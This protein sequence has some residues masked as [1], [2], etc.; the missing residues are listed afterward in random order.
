MNLHAFKEEC[1][2]R[3]RRKKDDEDIGERL[4]EGKQQLIRLTIDRSFNEL[5]NSHACYESEGAC[6]TGGQKKQRLSDF[7]LRLV[8]FSKTGGPDLN[9]EKNTDHDNIPQCQQEG[10]GEIEEK[11]C[12]RRRG[13]DSS[14]RPFC[15][16][17]SSQQR[18]GS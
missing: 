13:R 7:L 4:S 5:S 8:D 3:L 17:A 10:E 11:H 16:A 12:K 9:A 15:P 14:C 6:S 1:V 18:Q 2:T